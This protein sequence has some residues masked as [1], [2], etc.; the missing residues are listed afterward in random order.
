MVNQEYEPEKKYDG[1]YVCTACGHIANPRRITKGS[2]LIEIALWFF[3]IIPGLIYSL[4]RLTS[5]HSACPVC[6]SSAT[7]PIDTPKGRE[8]LKIYKPKKEKQ[9]EKKEK[10]QEKKK[11]NLFK[12]FIV[13]VVLP[14]ALFTLL[15]LIVD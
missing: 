12:A 8:L 13:F 4:W 10:T 1:E 9:S 2:L 7:I 6:G 5:R 14:L 15:G 11:G 3:L